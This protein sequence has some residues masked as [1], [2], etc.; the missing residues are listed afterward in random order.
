LKVIGSPC[1]AAKD[2]TEAG[3]GIMNPNVGCCYPEM[4]SIVLVVI[5]K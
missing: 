2:N 1:K 5:L 3:G 4:M